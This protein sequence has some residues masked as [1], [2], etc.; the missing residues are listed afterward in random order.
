V[1]DPA[2]RRSSAID[3]IEKRC[4]RCGA[5]RERGQEYC[6]E[7]G[8]RLP[9]VKGTIPA[10]RRSWLRRL[11]WYPGDWIWVSLLT[12]AV[13]AGGAAISIWLTSDDSGGSTTVVARAPVPVTATR[14]ITVPARPATTATFRT[15]TAAATTARITTLAPAPKAPPNGETVW[16]A[17]QNGWTLV[18]ISYP[19]AAGRAVPSAAAARAARAGLPQVGVLDS[20]DY[21]SLHPGYYVVFSG[22]YN[23]QA[24]AEA[25]LPSARAGGFGGA[26]TREISR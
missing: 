15:S 26:Y 22:V 12:L 1:A 11:G 4:P 5:A 6:A 2:S 16:P 7:C 23:S 3:T 25:A 20:A 10:L 13:A 19:S 14:R 9:S 24:E 21:S 18:L 17:G 8:S